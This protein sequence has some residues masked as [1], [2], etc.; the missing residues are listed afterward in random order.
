M[1]NDSFV[2]RGCIA[3]FERVRLASKIILPPAVDM[4]RNSAVIKFAFTDHTEFKNSKTGVKKHKA[5]CKFCSRERFIIET[6]GTTT[7]FTRH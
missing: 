7:A 2:S 4:S 6:V 1:G 3:A 5:K